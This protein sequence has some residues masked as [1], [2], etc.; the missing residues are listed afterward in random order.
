M[1]YCVQILHRVTLALRHVMMLAKVRVAIQIVPSLSVE[2]H[3]LTSQRE[4]HVMS[5]VAKPHCVILT[6]QLF[7]VEIA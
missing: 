4:R 7:H 1:A 2:T 3:R 5:E 6:A